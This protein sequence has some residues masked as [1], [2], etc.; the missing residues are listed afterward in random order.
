MSC[1]VGRSS[2]TETSC[3]P[4]QTQASCWGVPRTGFPAAGRDKWLFSPTKWEPSSGWSFRPGLPRAPPLLLAPHLE[5][6]LLTPGSWTY[7][8]RQ[9]AG[10][11]VA[12][13]REP[14]SQVTA[15][16]RG[17]HARPLESRTST[18]RGQRQARC[19]SGQRA[20]RS[21]GT[22]PG[23]E[24]ANADTHKDEAQRTRFKAQRDDSTYAARS[25]P[26][27][28]SKLIW[29]LPGPGRGGEHTKKGADEWTGSKIGKGARQDCI[30]SPCLFSSYAK[31]TMW[32][33]RLDEAQTGIKIARKN[34][35]N[36]RYADDTNLMAESEEELKSLCD[37]GERREWKAG[38]KLNIQKTKIMASSPITSWQIDGEK[39]ETVTD[40]IFLGSKITVDND[41]SHKI[42]RWLALWKK[43]YDK[44]R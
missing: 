34:I 38:L 13:W 2:P 3:F 21:D 6:T 25:L 19:P 5:Q 42:K 30:L 43:N 29:N 26:L 17:P 36:L 7:R 41:C 32:N 39:M 1:V 10:C 8:Q 18:V 22:L 16:G 28:E 33:T 24:E 12:G 35:N 31:Y 23:G 11:R 9:Q 20:Q 4:S 37:E 44:P 40:F 14:G 27:R 15:G